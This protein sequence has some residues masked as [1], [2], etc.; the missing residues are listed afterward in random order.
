MSSIFDLIINFIVPKT[1]Q[2]Y[3][4]SEQSLLEEF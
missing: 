2:Y 3:N 1:I 4:D